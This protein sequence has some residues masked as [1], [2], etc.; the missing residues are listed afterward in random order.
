MLLPEMRAAA[1]TRTPELQRVV[2]IT[3]DTST[4]PELEEFIVPCFHTTM[5]PSLQH[6]AGSEE[7]FDAVLADID[8]D[9]SVPEE[10]LE[11]LAAMRAKNDSLMLVALTRSL[12]PQ[13]R[14]KAAKAGI[15]EFF[16]APVDFRTLQVVLERGLEKRS[17]LRDPEETRELQGRYSFHELI[18]GSEPMLRVYEAIKRVADSSTT[19]MIRGESGT[20]KELVAKSIVAA[21]SRANKPFVS[22]NCAALPDSLIEAELFGYEKGAFTGAVVAKPGQFELAHGG[23]IFLDEIGTLG[24]ELQSKLLR[25]LEEH[26][27]Q[28]LGGKLPKRID[29]RLITATNEPLEEMVERGRFRQDLYYRIHVIPIFMPPLRERVGDVAV[30]A[31][32]FLRMYCAANKLPDKRFDLEALDILEENPWPGNVRELENLVQRLVL[33]VDGDVIGPQHLPKQILYQSAT[34]SEAMLIPEE[35][36][37]FDREMERIE[38]AYLRAALRR[39]GGRKVTAAALLKVNAQRMKYLCRKYQ[40]GPE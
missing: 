19:I 11:K 36:I 17:A 15:D 25:V 18:G 16:V 33:M 5:L 30:L 24:L 28:R 35:G 34:Q 27:V 23:T 2:I 7:A 9:G 37:D 3:T 14:R 8:E 1:A 21:G 32:H 31:E 26:T 22:L 40:L 10:A 12:D 20:G 13:L 38:Q 4:L 29:F 6:L 39:A